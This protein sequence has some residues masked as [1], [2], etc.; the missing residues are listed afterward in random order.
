[1]SSVKGHKAVEGIGLFFIESKAER[2]GEDR[3]GL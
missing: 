1:M 2:V 3:P